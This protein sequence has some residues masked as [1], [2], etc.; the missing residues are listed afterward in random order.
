MNKKKLS[1]EEITRAASEMIAEGGYANFSL[2]ELAAKLGVRPSSLYNHVDGIAQINVAVAMDA[3]TQMNRRL[4]IAIEGLEPDRAFLRGVEVYRAFA[5]ENPELYK[6]LFRFVDADPEN[7]ELIRRGAGFAIRP[8]RDIVSSYGLLEID[9]VNFMRML[10]AT[11][12]GFVTLA[13]E[14]FLHNPAVSRDESFEWMS[15]NLLSE[16]KQ[17]ACNGGKE[18]EAQ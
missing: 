2:R 18:E 11:L 6:S 3:A 8:L 17:M 12:H 16:L 15:G 5:F 4:T 10:R 14:G 9:R 7:R 1:G 13:Y